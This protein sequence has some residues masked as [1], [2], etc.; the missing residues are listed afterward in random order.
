MSSLFLSI[1]IIENE[2]DLR[3]LKGQIQFYA[4]ID[5]V[6]YLKHSNYY[7]H[8]TFLHKSA[9]QK[10]FRNIFH[11]NQ[12]KLT[13]VP[14]G[15]LCFWV[16]KK[17]SIEFSFYSLWV[18][19]IYKKDLTICHQTYFNLGVLF[20]F[21]TILVLLVLLQMTALY[22]CYGIIRYSKDNYFLKLI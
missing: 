7:A 8:R 10:T 9:L 22:V 11:F 3:I 6:E 12:E 15:P 20:F 21:S 1:C 18:P 17:I 16:K 14:R 5:I 4:S 2:S 13:S 19:Y